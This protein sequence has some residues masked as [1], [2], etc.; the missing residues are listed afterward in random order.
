LFPGPNLPLAGS[1]R[2]ML[3]CSKPA[4][5]AVKEEMWAGGFTACFKAS[6][7]A[8]GAV[9]RQ[10]LWGRGRHQGRAAAG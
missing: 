4:E 9:P 3:G 10:G 6:R 1:R 2:G 7:A 8:G 5:L